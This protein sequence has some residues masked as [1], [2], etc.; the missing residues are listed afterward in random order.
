MRDRRSVSCGTTCRILTVR[1]LPWNIVFSIFVVLAIGGCDYQPSPNQNRAITHTPPPNPAWLPTSFFPAWKDAVP[2]S[3]INLYYDST[4]GQE[5]NGLILKSAIQGLTAGQRLVIGPGTWSIS[6]KFDVVLQGTSTNPIWI[7]GDPN[8]R[9][10]I[11]RPDTG[12]NVMNVG[13]SGATKFV[14]FSGLEFTGGDTL[15]K[16][17]D[18][19]NIWIDYCYIHDGDGVGISAN[20][21]DTNHIYI[22]NN[23]IVRPGNL[24]D[25]G[26]GL[27]LGGNNGSVIMSY[28]VIARNYVHDTANADQGDGIELKQG[29]HHN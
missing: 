18:C 15:V 23:E 27:Y 19:S 11:T 1:T 2:G 28:S 3:T 29:S 9:P 12:Q 5:A 25:M 16:L 20:A 10:I 4:I 22:T 8:N 14:A 26:E 17:Y 7:T 21:S 13:E 24:G 6:P